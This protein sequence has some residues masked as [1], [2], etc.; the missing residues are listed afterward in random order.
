MTML[1]LMLIYLIFSQP[2][3]SQEKDKPVLLINPVVHTG[4]GEIFENAALAFEGETISLLADARLIRLDMSAYEVI[5]AFGL[6]VYPAA[7]VENLPEAENLRQTIYFTTLEEG[8]SYLLTSAEES[9]AGLLNVLGEGAAATFVVTEHP[10]D[11]STPL[12]RYMV[13]KGRVK[14]ENNV[15]LQQLTGE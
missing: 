3:C 15:S 7:V 4:S 6:H 11:E 9:G 5:E 2:A 14:R 1:R 10:L 8:R 12:L 13:V